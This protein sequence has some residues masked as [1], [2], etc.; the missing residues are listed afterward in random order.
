MAGI[1]V[2]P[3]PINPN[4]DLTVD[5]KP[6]VDFDKLLDDLNSIEKP[7]APTAVLTDDADTKAQVKEILEKML[8]KTP[9]EAA[10]IID[11]L[12][13]TDTDKVLKALKKLLESVDKAV[14]DQTL[15][16][17]VQELV[18]SVFSKAGQ[19]PED[20][21]TDALAEIQLA[22]EKLKK[23]SDLSSN[24]I[25]AQLIPLLAALGQAQMNSQKDRDEVQTTDGMVNF[26]E[27]NSSYLSIPTSTLQKN[28]NE[29]IQRAEGTFVG[30]KTEIVEAIKLKADTLISG[31]GIKP[32]DV[33]VAVDENGN[34]SLKFPNF[35]NEEAAKLAFGEKYDT[36]IE[37][38]KKIGTTTDLV[39]SFTP[40]TE[41]PVIPPVDVKPIIPPTEGEGT[42]P[43]VPPTEGE[44]TT[45]TVPPVD[46]ET[47]PPTTE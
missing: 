30:D 27:D 15:T 4:Y 47:V 42:T 24:E 34:V 22:I 38:M 26:G 19:T 35:E 21:A 25:L 20:G 39:I 12:D 28:L 3:I 11:G 9:E 5:K 17:E 44:G 10:K 14:G 7:K 6:E 2:N 23:D 1:I 8:N 13:K 16:K 33:Q 18:N 45:P 46:G 40:K 31:L 43:T 29:I 32:E 41:E 37:G 36:L